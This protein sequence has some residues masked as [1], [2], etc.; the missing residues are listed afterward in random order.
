MN[1]FVIIGL[2]GAMVAIDTT[3]FGQFMVSQPLFSSALAGYIFGDV[4][5]GIQVGIIMQLIWLKL[6][7][8]GGTIFLNGN[9]GTLTAVCAMFLVIDQ[10]PYSKESLMF[11]TIIIGIVL[12][13]VYGYFTVLQ[14]K[15]INEFL[16]EKALSS[17]RERNIRL[18]QFYHFSGVVVTAM[19]GIVICVVFSYAAKTVLGLIPSSYYTTFSNYFPYGLYA[20]TGMGIGTVLSMA[21]TKK[22]W[23]LPL[24]GI[25]AGT[26]LLLT[27]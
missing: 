17:L 24:S 19:S 15:N 5:A 2:L 11:T 9:L 18:F 23:Y 6:V 25:A 26:L 1:E 8:A 7:P 27:R 10:F 13:Y 3:V 14:R 21:W 4:G 16:C 22:L 20:L 12:S